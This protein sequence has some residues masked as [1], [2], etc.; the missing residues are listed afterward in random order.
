MRIVRY[1]ALAFIG[2][3]TDEGKD[4]AGEGEGKPAQLKFCQYCGS[5]IPFESHFC[6]QCGTNIELKPA[7]QAPRKELSIQRFVEKFMNRRRSILVLLSLI[8]LM[9]STFIGSLSSVPPENAQKIINDTMQAFGH[10][11]S[12]LDILFNNAF[13]SLLLCI[14]L[15]GTYILALAS[16]NTGIFIAALAQLSGD[17]SMELF[18]TLLGVPWTWFEFA[19]FS[20]ASAQGMLFLYTLFR[21]KWRMELRNVVISLTICLGLLLI[22]AGL[23]TFLLQRG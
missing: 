11:P 6:P 5:T 23:E 10:N 9:V 13:I 7:L 4:T 8:I 1:L 19:A 3:S 20:I 18:L 2:D 22:G 14:P 21:G 15:Y 16:H 12:W 17:T